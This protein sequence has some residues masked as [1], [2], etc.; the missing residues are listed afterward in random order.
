MNDMIQM[1]FS[2]DKEDR[3]KMRVEV[4]SKGYV[5]GELHSHVKGILDMDNPAYEW[6]LVDHLQGSHHDGE[7][8]QWFTIWE[9]THNLNWSLYRVNPLCKI[10]EK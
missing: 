8:G 10:E 7:G 9:V 2:E 1:S 5:S 3:Q 6:K 4:T